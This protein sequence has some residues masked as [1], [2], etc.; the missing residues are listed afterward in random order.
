VPTG[1]LLQVGDTDFDFRTARP[2]GTTLLDTPFALD[3]ATTCAAKVYSPV[4]GLCLE[5]FTNQPAIVVYT[6]EA[7]PSICLETQ[8]YP[9]APRHG[10]FPSSL[11]RP[12]ET[13]VN[14]SRFAFS[15]VR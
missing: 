15:E 1:R 12:G 11:L 14:E 7:F 5:V 3:D 6:P 9:D 2:L 13:Y 10:H 4:S 8:N